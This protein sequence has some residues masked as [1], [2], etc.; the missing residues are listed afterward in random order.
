MP[1][2]LNTIISN[3][4]RFMAYEMIK[5]LKTQ[6]KETLLDELHGYVKKNERKKGQIHKVF[7]DSFDAKECISEKF[8]EQKIRYIHHNPVMKKWNLA[9]DF[10]SY[11]HSSAAF[12][13][14]ES[15]GY[16]R[17]LHIVDI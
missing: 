16:Q 1:S 15:K 2:P 10:I 6:K 8:I 9:S 12:Y 7:E 3:G 17:L 11:Q 13:E 5:R 4:K 14:K